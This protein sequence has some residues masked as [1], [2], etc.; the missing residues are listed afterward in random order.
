MGQ[1]QAA[2]FFVVTKAFRQ[3][4]AGRSLQGLESCFA[5]KINAA[6]STG[7]MQFCPKPCMLDLTQFNT[8]VVPSLIPINW[9]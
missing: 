1:A 2:M 7:A 3:I 8:W 9:R 5:D 4:P 6:G